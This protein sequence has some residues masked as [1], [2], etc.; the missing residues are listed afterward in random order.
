MSNSPQQ[1]LAKARQNAIHG[2]LHK[3]LA[4]TRINIGMS[5]CEIAAGSK[6]VWQVMEE[7]IKKRKLTDIHLGRKGCV[8]RCH[9]EPTV[10]VYQAG[11]A[12]FKYENVDAA[13]A[14]KIIIDH[15]VKKNMPCPSK[16]TGKKLVSK[17]TLTDKSHF[18]FSDIDYFNKQKRMALRNCGVIDPENIDDYLAIRGYEALAK[19]LGEYTPDRVIEEV[20]KSGLRGRG[21]GGFPTGTKWRFVADQKAGKKYLICNADEGDPGAFMDRSVIEGDPFSV[22]E[23][24]AIGGY[25][26]GADQGIVY[27]R[28]EYPLAVE[29]LKIAIKQAKKLNLLGKNILGTDFSFDINIVLGA[30]AFVCGEETALINSIQGERGMPKVKPPFPSTSGLWGQPTLINNVETWANIP[31]IVLDGYEHF[32]SIGTEKSKGTKVF[33]LAGKVKNTGLVEVPMGTTL[34]EVIFDIGGGIKEGRKFK[35]AQTGGPSGGCLPV[36]YLNTPI[37]YDSLASAGSIMGSGGLIVMD[38]KDCMVD[39]A[40]FFLE[41]TQDESCGKCTPCREGTKRMLEILNRITSGQG[42]L[43]DIDKLESLGETIKKTALCGLGQTAPNPVLST[44]RF[45]RAEYEAHIKERRCPSAVCA[46]LFVSPCQHTCPAHIDIPGF[47]SLI[48]EGKFKESAEMILQRNPF[49]SI[50]GRVCHHPCESNCRRGKIEEPV[51]IMLLKRFAADYTVSDNVKIEKYTGKQLKEKVAVIGS[52]PAGL[53]CAYQ[54]AKRGYQVTVFE[55]DRKPGGMLTL[56]IPEYRLPKEVV[57][58]EIKRITDLGVKIKTN[59]ALGK[60]ISLKKLKDQGFKVVYLAIGAW[61]EAALGIPGTELVGFLGSLNFLKDY[62]SERIKKMHGAYALMKGKSKIVF[63]G[64]KVAVIGGGNAAMDVARTCRR[65][66]ADEVHVIYRRTKDA[67]PAI[68]EEVEEAEKEGVKFHFLLIPTT[69]KGQ[70][71]QVVSLECAYTRPGEFDLSGRRKPLATEEVFSLPVDIVISAIGGKPDIPEAVKKELG[72]KDTGALSVDRETLATN[73]PGVFAGGDLV[74]GGA[75]VIEAIADGE[76]AAISIERSFKGEDLRKN[77][78]VIKG[79]R[80]IVSDFDPSAEIKEK[81]RPQ[82]AKVSMVKR[83]QAFTEVELGY[84]KKQ[85][86]E[87]ANRCLRCDRKEEECKP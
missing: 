18:I 53:S 31:V 48:K 71:N 2:N 11:K 14:R 74:S 41:F 80:R 16:K 38:E 42:E 63:T 44:L 50:C 52:G 61:K 51:A 40:K 43:S 87:E 7:E 79:Q 82:Q 19:V 27:I 26:V 5:T 75:T 30:G 39:V 25:A 81:N 36:Q 13:K 20:I 66:G 73:V 65:L 62:N 85:A 57:K 1:V 59:T 58:R 76:K 6:V 17:D 47:I 9:L 83:L 37:D 86:L 67:M 84:S 70:D 8:G 54:L 21:G 29:R 24:M 3:W 60:E 68:P 34:G 35:T 49:P 72:I 64:K 12:P 28:A 15:L 22:L 4:P 45:F 55:A 69:I 78:Y 77:R 23:A 46:D 32:A 33:A 56:G 10:E